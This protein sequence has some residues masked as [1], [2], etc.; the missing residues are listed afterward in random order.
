LAQKTGG[1]GVYT[2]DDVQ[3]IVDT[4]KCQH[5]QKPID[6]PNRRKLTEY[7]DVCRNCNG[8][9]CL[10]P[11][12]HVCTPWMKTIEAIEAAFYKREQF[13]KTLGL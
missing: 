8:F 4:A 5:C 12:C 2:C 11:E 9:I 7:A 1:V 3:I 6:I 10:R 13:R